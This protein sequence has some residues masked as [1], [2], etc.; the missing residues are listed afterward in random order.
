M[1][2]ATPSL[3]PN[4]LKYNQL[5]EAANYPDSDIQEQLL[6]DAIQRKFHPDSAELNAIRE[7]L[8]DKVQG[9]LDMH[10]PPETPG[11]LCLPGDDDFDELATE[12]G[13]EVPDQNPEDTMNALDTIIQELMSP[14]AITQP[15]IVYDEGLLRT[16]YILHMRLDTYQSALRAVVCGAHLEKQGIADGKDLSIAAGRRAQELYEEQN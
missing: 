14:S 1:P 16:L 5:L 15:N 10:S 8:G 13:F 9:L 11:A 7:Y 2:D 3:Y 12:L 6:L 4:D